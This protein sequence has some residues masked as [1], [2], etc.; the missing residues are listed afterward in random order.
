MRRRRP[1]PSCRGLHTGSPSRPACL[2]QAQQPQ[3]P[4]I[5]EL[6]RHRADA[7]GLAE[8]RTRPDPDGEEAANAILAVM[9]GLQIQWL[10]VP[11]SIGMAAS[12]DRVITALLNRSH[13][14]PH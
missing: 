9:D 8:S 11:D 3:H 10:L 5:D 13:G 7:Y 12:T 1:D 6:L 4:V 14:R 2:G